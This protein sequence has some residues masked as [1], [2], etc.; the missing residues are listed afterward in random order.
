MRD[1]GAVETCVAQPKTAVF[2]HERFPSV[3]DKAAAYCYF[4][5]KA[6]P[7]FDGNKRTGLVA[8]LTYLLSA[9]LVPL[10]NKEDMYALI[11]GIAKGEVE[12]EQMA[13]AFQ[14]ACQGRG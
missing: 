9:G 11:T 8:A 5:V 10:F 4:I 1:A 3:Y 14:E 12:I 6:H 7:F 2:G 13:L